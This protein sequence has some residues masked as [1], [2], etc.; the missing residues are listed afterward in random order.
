MLVNVSKRPV[1]KCAGNATGMRRDAKHTTAQPE[2]IERGK[3]RNERKLSLKQNHEQITGR[4]D[5][6]RRRRGTRTPHRRRGAGPGVVT[7]Q[8]IE[9]LHNALLEVLHNALLEVLHNALLEVL[10][11]ALLEIIT[12]GT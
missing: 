12:H 9:T 7:L 2:K 10:H 6:G 1:R 3:L 5:G 4:A 8:Y 11:S